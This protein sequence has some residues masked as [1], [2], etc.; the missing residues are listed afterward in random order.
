M[1]VNEKLVR[2]YLRSFD[3]RNLFLDSLGWDRHVGSINVSVDNE[4]FEVMAVGE[5][6]GIVLVQRQYESEGFVLR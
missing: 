1:P 4:T 6:R 3:F 5:K 2:Q